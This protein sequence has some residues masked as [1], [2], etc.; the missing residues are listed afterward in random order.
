MKSFATLVTALSL[1]MQ[2]SAQNIGINCDGSA[3][4]HTA[5]LDINGDALPNNGKRGLLIPRVTTTQRDLMVTS[6]SLLVYNT[7][8]SCFNFWSSLA[9]WQAFGCAEK[10][11]MIGYGGGVGNSGRIVIENAYQDIDVRIMYD[12]TDLFV[13]LL[14]QNLQHRNVL[15]DWNLASSMRSAVT[16]DGVLYILVVAGIPNP[17][18]WRVYRYDITDI[19]SGGILMNF[20][21]QSLSGTDFDMEMTANSSGNF[22]FTYNAGNSANDYSVARYSVAGTTF[23]HLGSVNYGGISNSFARILVDAMGN[24]YGLASSGATVIRKFDPLGVQIYVTPTYMV[25]LSAGRVLNWSDT[26][27]FGDSSVDRILN[28]VYLE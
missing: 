20:V 1:C 8:T 15:L 13:E 16:L 14:D 22:Y 18:E 5:L 27:Y 24:V 19:A 9:G 7:S 11:R 10:P 25:S 4:H 21:G 23:S 6:E 28:R 26:F 2:V 17:N 3:P 12:A